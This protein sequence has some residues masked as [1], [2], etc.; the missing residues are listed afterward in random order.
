[1]L[2][3]TQLTPADQKA[4]PPYDT[5][6]SNKSS[7]KGGEMRGGFSVIT[8][9]FTTVTFFSQNGRTTAH[10]NGQHIPLFGLLAYMAFVFPIKP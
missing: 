8:F 2:E 3:G 1:M 4:I 10:Q 9:F 5:V 7:R 6:L